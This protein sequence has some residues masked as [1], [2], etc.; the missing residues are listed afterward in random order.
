VGALEAGM[1]SREYSEWLALR[2]FDPGPHD[3]QIATLHALVL[4]VNLWSKKKFEPFDFL[5]QTKPRREQTMDE[6]VAAFAAACGGMRVV[7]LTGGG[8]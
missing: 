2:R 8:A 4:M 3:L 7:D 1:S 6:F 5:P